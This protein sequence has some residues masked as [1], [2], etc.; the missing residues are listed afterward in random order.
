MISVLRPISIG[1]VLAN[2]EL[3]SNVIMVHPTEMFPAMDGTLNAQ[4][5]QMASTGIDADGV[6]YADEVTT[7]TGVP[8]T[9]LPMGSNR[10]SSPDVRRKERVQLWQ[11]ADED[12]YYWTTLG[13]D[14]DKR[15]LETVILVISND[16]NP[17]EDSARSLENCY[18]MEFSTHKGLVTFQTNRSN[19]EPFAF[20][21]QYN[22]KEGRVILTD[23]VGTSIT[24]NSMEDYLLFRNRFETLIE[25]SKKSINAKAPESMS[26]EAKDTIRMECS[27]FMV[28]AKEV[29]FDAAQSTFK[30][31]VKTTGNMEVAGDFSGGGVKASGGT[32]TADNVKTKTIRADNYQNLP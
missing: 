10:F 2:K 14:D 1:H 26:F 5:Q 18:F 6:Q 25:I 13:L 24:L 22:T 27:K 17:D 7:S 30:G 9:W 29:L 32:F 20:T 8:A 4:E 31:N 15:R 3:G 19:G 12:A 23:D 21:T 16:P 28:K 11:F